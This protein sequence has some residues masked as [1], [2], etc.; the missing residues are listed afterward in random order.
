[1]STKLEARLKEI[2]SSSYSREDK[3]RMIRLAIR[4]AETAE[5]VRGANNFTHSPR[6]ESGEC[7]WPNQNPLDLVTERGSWRDNE[8]ENN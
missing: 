2:E 6:T 5:S 1:M 4:N 8:L 7:Y 3:D